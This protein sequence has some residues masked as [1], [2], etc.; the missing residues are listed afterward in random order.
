[1][2]LP[3]IDPRLQ[4]IHSRTT[5]LLAQLEHMERS[6]T[7]R[8]EMYIKI[9]HIVICAHQTSTPTQ[10]GF[11]IAP[12]AHPKRGL[13]NK[14]VLLNVS[15]V[16]KDKFILPTPLR[17]IAELVLASTRSPLAIEDSTHL[18]KVT[19]LT[20][21]KSAHLELYVTVAQRSTLSGA[22]I[23]A[24]VLTMTRHCWLQTSKHK[25]ALR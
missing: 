9:M 3:P 6:S 12:L 15:L 1:M 4:L 13:S 10:R 8:N 5:A 23:A 14:V 16:R 20:N 21:V 11:R 25:V 22:G 18:S 19:L 2:G 7:T 17:R 24:T